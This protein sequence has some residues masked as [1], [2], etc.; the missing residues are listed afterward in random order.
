MST[1]LD[2]CIGC[3]N[4]FYNLGG[5]GAKQCWKLKDA[6]KVIRVQVGIWQPPPYR[7]TP[8]ETN[9]CNQPDGSRFLTRDD[10]RVVD[11]TDEAVAAWH[12]E[13]NP[14]GTDS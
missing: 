13:H 6:R 10:P 4:H 12:K 14:E 9:H 8:K 1:K 3:H 7:W 2:R 5:G 11:N